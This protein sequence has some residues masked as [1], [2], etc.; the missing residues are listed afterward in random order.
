MKRIIFFALTIMM[1][2]LIITGCKESEKST[3]DNITDL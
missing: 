3:S 2:S 1:L